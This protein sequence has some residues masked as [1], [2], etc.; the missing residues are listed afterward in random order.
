MDYE[1]DDEI[2]ESDQDEAE[3]R[4]SGNKLDEQRKIWGGKGN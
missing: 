4:T 1:S 3:S 2:E